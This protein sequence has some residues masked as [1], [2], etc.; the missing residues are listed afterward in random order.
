MHC[1]ACGVE[2]VEAAVYCH[3]CG[4]RLLPAEDGPPRAGAPAEAGKPEAT[5]V[6]EPATLLRREAQDE[7]EEELWHGGYSSRAMSGAWIASGLVSLVLLV[8]GI[9]WG[10]NRHLVAHPHGGDNPALA[11]LLRGPVL[12]PHERSL[13]AHHATIYP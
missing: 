4:Q 9:L 12:S 13:S 10:A 8:V 6:A 11:L 5:E 2:V 7:P 3:K 1:P